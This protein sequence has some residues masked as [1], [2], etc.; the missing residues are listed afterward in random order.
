MT[1]FYVWQWEDEHGKWNPYQA[2]AAVKLEN[3]KQEGDGSVELNIFNREYVVDLGT[4]KQVNN[5]T[6]VCRNV[7]RIKAGRYILYYI[8]L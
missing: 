6:E 3:T 4:M 5:D 7:Q 1:E 2:K 8:P